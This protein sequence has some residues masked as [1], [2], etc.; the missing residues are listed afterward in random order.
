MRAL[1]L[2]LWLVGF[3]GNKDAAD[4]GS[5]TDVPGGSP[6]DRCE[7]IPTYEVDGLAC[8]QVRDAFDT[9]VGA[10]DRCTIDAN[11]TRLT[12]GSCGLA[13]EYVVNDC[14]DVAE[15]TAYYTKANSCAAQQ[16][17]TCEGTPPEPRCVEGRCE[18]V[19]SDR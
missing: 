1:V 5:D 19:Y 4:T 16:G 9:M 13:C 14:L 10:A 7:G 15:L 2:G 11:C 18:L 17:C 3:G 8:T 6:E 12:P